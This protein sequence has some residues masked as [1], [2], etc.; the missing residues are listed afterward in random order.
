MKKN[1]RSL[2]ALCVQRERERE[3]REP[4]LLLA[5]PFATAQLTESEEARRR[6]SRGL[7]QREREALGREA[8]ER[9]GKGEANRENRARRV[10]H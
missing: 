7:G 5:P 3:T 6:R 9:G 4:Q 10:I 2:S 1:A 8:I